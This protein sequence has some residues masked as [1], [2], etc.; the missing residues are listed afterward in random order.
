MIRQKVNFRDK[1]GPADI[2]FAI[3]WND[4]WGFDINIVGF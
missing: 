2:L 4:F 3:N 1:L